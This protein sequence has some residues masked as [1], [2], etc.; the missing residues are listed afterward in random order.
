[1]VAFSKELDKIY[2]L[3]IPD[4]RDFTYAYFTKLGIIDRIH[5]MEAYTPDSSH[6]IS[7]ISKNLIFPIYMENTA[8]ISNYLGIV[9]I[10]KDIVRNKYEY[11]MI[12]EDDVIFLK[13]YFHIGN[14]WLTKAAISS[15]INTT[16]PYCLYLQSNTADKNIGSDNF[17]NGNIV[18]RSVKYGEPVCIVNYQLCELL[19]KYAFPI[20]SPFDE[21]KNEI[22]QK[23][24]VQQAILIPYICRELSHNSYKYDMKKLGFTFR[25]SLGTGKSIFLQYPNIVFNLTLGIDVNY[26]RLVKHL[27]NA[28]N[29]NI[30]VG[31]NNLDNESMKFNFDRATSLSNTYIAGGTVSDNITWHDKSFIISV[32]GKK[33]CDVINRKFKFTPIIGDF[34]LLYHRFVKFDVIKKYEICFILNNNIT[35]NNY[36]SCM[37]YTTTDVDDQLQA[38]NMSQ[39]VVTDNIYYVI[40]SH[41]YG[42]PATLVTLNPTNIRD[43]CII[44]D[45][46]ST[47]HTGQINPIIL[48]TILHP[49]ETS[50]IKKFPQ[51]ILP[52]SSEYID[53][54]VDICPFVPKQHRSFVAKKLF[55]QVFS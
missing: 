48:Q 29:P 32:R 49:M 27:V 41:S 47:F 50:I 6:T 37:N 5:I 36:N 54:L 30:S 46:Y 11:A 28:I 25:K 26:Q 16:R 3:S 7:T 17:P 38:I 2:C 4:R 18:M 45:Y 22:K 10:M 1:M 31:T 12:M 14:R 24:G 35:V 43:R 21:Y 20:T 55:V 34:L 39:H 40:I 13:E 51:P 53:T 8:N 44:D 15:K 52:Y 19:L 23:F 33:S 42:I 9:E